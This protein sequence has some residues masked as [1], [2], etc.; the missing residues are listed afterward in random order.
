MLTELVETS[1]KR[2]REVEA[3]GFGIP[4][5]IDYDRRSGGLVGASADRS[6]LAFADV[7][8]ERLALPVFMDND[9]N[10]A[11]LAEHRAGAARG[12]RNAVML[13]L[14]T[15]IAGAI[16]IG[17]EIYRGSQGAAGELGH[18]VI[19]ADGPDCGPGCPSRGCLES[20]ASGTALVREALSVAQD[21]PHTRLGKALQSG[22]E[23]TGPL[24]SE[25]AHDGD[26]EAI[27]L[28][29]A[30]GEWLGVA[31]A[32]IVNVFNPDVVVIGG[33]VIAAGELILAPARRVMRERALALP[34][35][36]VRVLAA[37]YG[38]E[39]GMLGAALL[40]RDRL[41]GR[42]RV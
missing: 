27:A 9:G 19:S 39:A 32:G 31:L 26:A 12:E 24:V 2:R 5:L 37:H 3:V 23:I 13:T 10:L 25:L 18:V 4:C 41:A 29:A 30:L 7:M 28:L 17:G 8:A 38:A 6:E 1:A 16:M 36:H 35:A 21:R 20:L 33:G 42:V 22:R 11:L 40:A 14:G 34:A 15:G